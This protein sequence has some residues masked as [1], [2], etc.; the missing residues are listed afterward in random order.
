MYLDQVASFSLL[1]RFC[2]RIVAV[3]GMP[4]PLG[5][6]SQVEATIETAVKGA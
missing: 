6:S 3:D 1:S 4:P 2:G 5:H